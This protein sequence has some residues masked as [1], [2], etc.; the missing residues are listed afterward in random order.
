MGVGVVGLDWGR[1]VDVGVPGREESGK[2]WDVGG[3]AHTT[4]MAS[5]SS[6]SRMRVVKDRE[7]GGD[8]CAGDARVADTRS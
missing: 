7:G 6:S 3:R 1:E 2:C 4:D 8:S 5:L